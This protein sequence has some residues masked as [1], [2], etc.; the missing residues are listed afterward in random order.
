MYKYKETRELRLLIYRQ[1]SREYGELTSIGEYQI[2]ERIKFDDGRAKRD[3]DLEI[4]RSGA[5]SGLRHR[6]LFRLSIQTCS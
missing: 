2:N 6:R 5:R 4:S 1:Y 3:R